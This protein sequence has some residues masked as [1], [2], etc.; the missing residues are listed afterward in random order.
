MTWTR[1]LT[2]FCTS[3]DATK[4]T[5]VGTVA[6]PGRNLIWTSELRAL[7]FNRVTSEFGPFSNWGGA[8]YPRGKAEKMQ[9][10]LK[11]L[12][13]QISNRCRRSITWQAVKNQLE[14]GITQ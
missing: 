3:F 1:S 8:A 7:V 4:A 14:W 11:E 13:A 2:R 5:P 12:A 9:A 6:M 10:V